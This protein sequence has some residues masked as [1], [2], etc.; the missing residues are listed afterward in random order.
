M[1]L[2]TYSSYGLPADRICDKLRKK[3]ASICALKYEEPI[4]LEGVNLKKLRVKK[5]K[6]ILSQWGEPCRGCVDKSQ[7]VKKVESLR[8]KHDPSW[9][10]EKDL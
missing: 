5:L 9:T 4:K 2:L 3:D 10:G 8:P 7:F 6:E 1:L